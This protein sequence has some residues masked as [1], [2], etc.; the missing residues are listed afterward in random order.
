MLTPRRYFTILYYT[1]YEYLPERIE[2]MAKLNML[3]PHNLSQDEA[4]K[5]I[6]KDLDNLK[7]QF[8]DEISDLQE[9]W[10]GNTCE[11][12][13]SVKG[14]SVSGAMV[15]KPSEIEIAGNLPFFAIP[16]KGKIESTIRERFKQ[17]LG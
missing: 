11:G 14:F 8:A 1:I 5:R 3:I 17:L 7:I 13:L 10:N 6:K 2:N 12:H 4:M 9:N 16:F 15:I